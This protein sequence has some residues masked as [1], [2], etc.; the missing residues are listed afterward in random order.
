M[1]FCVVHELHVACFKQL[2]ATLR[3]FIQ[4][5]PNLSTKSK[6]AKESV[7]RGEIDHAKRV[8][9]Q[10]DPRLLEL[11]IE[12]D[13]DELIDLVHFASSESQH[14]FEWCVHWYMLH[15]FT[16]ATSQGPSALNAP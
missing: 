14:H 8:L 13:I 7:G 6:V 3:P 4:G 5:Y 1:R 11:P 2:F 16:T 10:D 12:V 9:S 15:A